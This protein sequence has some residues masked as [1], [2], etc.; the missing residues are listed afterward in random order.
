MTY[1]IIPPLSRYN[2]SWKDPGGFL[3]HTSGIAPIL[4]TA[5]RLLFSPSRTLP[6]YD[7]IHSCLNQKIPPTEDCRL[8]W[9]DLDQDQQ[10]RIISL[11]CVERYTNPTKQK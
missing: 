7:E 6:Q 2:A 8:F 9:K 10:P 5:R 3:V 4:H 11:E 1:H